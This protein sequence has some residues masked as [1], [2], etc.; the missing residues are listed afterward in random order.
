MGAAQAPK[1]LWISFLARA[2]KAKLRDHVGAVLT[3]SI[4]VG[5]NRFLAKTASNMEKPDG[6]VVIQPEDLPE[7]LF[8]LKLQDLNGIAGAM[9]E[10]LERHGIRTV[11]ALCRADREH[12]RRVWGGVEGERMYDRLRGENVVLPP[13]QRSSLGHSHVLPPRLR[14]DAGAF[15]VLSKLTQKAALRLRAEG[16]LAGRLGLRVSY[17]RHGDWGLETRFAPMQDT[18]A[19]LRLLAALW[20]ER[21]R[22]R[23]PVK[24]AMVFSELLPCGKASLPL[25]PDAAR[26]P[27]LDSALDGVRLKFGPKALYFGSAFLAQEQAP[28]RISF[29]H[30]PDL[31]LEADT[32]AGGLSE[33]ALLEV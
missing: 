32:R 24:V 25:F 18:L 13:T 10:R 33:R 20:A 31:R 15:A 3:C 30:I 19:C 7:C 9:L 8:R 5:P 6:L 14:H 21:P 26:S 12:L 29:T 23:E 1:S 4:G 22:R 16:L 27:G 17:R 2:V 28:M 11:A